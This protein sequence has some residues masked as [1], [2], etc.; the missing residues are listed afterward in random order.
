MI[1]RP[2]APS[3]PTPVSIG[4]STVAATHYQGQAPLLA[5]LP[6]TTGSML[7]SPSLKNGRI[8]HSLAIRPRADYGF[9]PAGEER[10]P[11]DSK[12]LLRHPALIRRA[13]RESS[14]SESEDQF[15]DVADDFDDTI[16]HVSE[17]PFSTDIRQ[18]SEGPQCRA[19]GSIGRRSQETTWD[20][21]EFQSHA[22]DRSSKYSVG[23]RYEGE[24]TEVYDDNTSEPEYDARSTY[25]HA[26]N[27]SV[28][29][30]IWAGRGAFFSP[31]PAD[32]VVSN[33]YDSARGPKRKASAPAAKVP[34]L[35]TSSVAFQHFRNAAEYS[36]PTN[37]QDANLSSTLRQP[38]P[39]TQQGRSGLLSAYSS[40]NLAV[41]SQISDSRDFEHHMAGIAKLATSKGLQSKPITSASYERT[42]ASD[43]SDSRSTAKS[44]VSK[45]ERS[46]RSPV[47]SYDAGVK[48]KRVL[49][50][51]HT[52]AEPFE[53]AVAGGIVH[54]LGVVHDGDLERRISHL[55]PK[56]RKHEPAPWELEGGDVSESGSLS[57]I[58]LPSSPLPQSAW[59]KLTRGSLDVR[60]RDGL[61]VKKGLGLGVNLRTSSSDL[62]RPSTDFN[63]SREASSQDARPLSGASPSPARGPQ[64]RLQSLGSNSGHILQYAVPPE[65]KGDSSSEGYSRVQNIAITSTTIG[66][67]SD[68]V[69]SAAPSASRSPRSRT[70]SVTTS[71]AN[72]LKGFG[73][74]SERKDKPTEGSQNSNKLA[75]ALKKKGE[76][77]ELSLAKGIS[78]A[79]F[80]KQI[81]QESETPLISSAIRAGANKNFLNPFPDRAGKD[82]SQVSADPSVKVKN[83]VPSST[84]SRSETRVQNETFS[85]CSAGVSDA[86]AAMSPAPYPIVLPS[87]DDARN[88]TT[89]TIDTHSTNSF[90]GVN[91]SQSTD[92]TSV[93]DTAKVLPA[94]D[95]ATRNTQSLSNP[96]IVR[97]TSYVLHQ[98]PSVSISAGMAASASTTSASTPMRGMGLGYRKTG[99]TTG[100]S[101]SPSNTSTSTSGFP[102]SPARQGSVEFCAASPLSPR[103]KVMALVADGAASADLLRSASITPI[104][105]FDTVKSSESLQSQPEASSVDQDSG[106]SPKVAMES[107]W[108]AHR[109]SA[110]PS[111]LSNASLPI[112]GSHEGVSYKLISLEQAQA[113]ERAKQQSSRKNSSSEIN[114]DGCRTAHMAESA[115][116]AMS[117][118]TAEDGPESCE[119]SQ[120]SRVMRGKKSGLL[121]GMFGRE[122][123]PSRGQGEHPLPLSTSQQSGLLPSSQTLKSMK[124]FAATEGD[125]NAGAKDD[126]GDLPG[127]R[128]LGLPAL[129]S[130]R[131]VSSI[132]ASLS[133]ALLEKQPTSCILNSQQAYMVKAAAQAFEG[134]GPSSTMS[135]SLLGTDTSSHLSVA[136]GHSPT[137]IVTPPYKTI[138]S[139]VCPT[140][141]V[142]SSG[143]ESST[144]SIFHSPATSPGQLNF[145]DG[146]HKDPNVSSSQGGRNSGEDESAGLAFASNVARPSQLSKGPPKS[147][148]EPTSTKLRCIHTT[149]N[150][151]G[152]S[153]G[154]VEESDNT[155]GPSRFVKSFPAAPSTSCDKDSVEAQMTAAVK[156]RVTEIEACITDLLSEL[157]HLRMTHIPDASV[158]ASAPPMHL[159]RSDI[160]A[161]AK[162]ERSPSFPHCAASSGMIL[163]EVASSTALSDTPAV[164][165][166]SAC[167]CSCA[168]MKRLQ[169]INETQVLRGI[170]SSV[171]DRGRGV[172]KRSEE[173]ASRF[174]GH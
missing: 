5:T 56:V 76:R 173:A 82:P 158:S 50:S 26:R 151:S 106:S 3:G 99:S 120:G 71:A 132:F 131:P 79:D 85:K 116:N 96:S 111:T 69:Y 126:L 108:K 11:D 166:C 87:L 45:R 172:R 61:D 38:S 20:E 118:V 125:P 73:L 88:S 17:G 100:G 47:L 168:E 52:Q 138:K 75:K 51:Q 43:R 58:P 54:G 103:L 35:P 139:E 97:K 128:N 153:T 90:A 133:P 40:P 104:A 93:S 81:A 49:N 162:Q 135:S 33:A 74:G 147:I 114:S 41:E 29:S 66:R 110:M 89:T 92:Q 115:L 127:P 60:D 156:V 164:P 67:T 8:A 39:G 145:Y 152:G 134:N 86:T 72:M 159:S 144:G 160:K 161:R 129:G 21:S 16:N 6:H 167:G 165:A 119:K 13:Q 25:G 112:P 123:L 154:V 78:S 64:T 122:K 18:L 14:S 109:P 63:G 46:K 121:K 95:T 101:L 55:G 27:S 15:K 44:V 102:C 130:I 1:V 157:T 23:T 171:M 155:S 12:T 174:G 142:I 136:R 80:Q 10:L 140:E 24:G 94:K 149:A 105:G 146:T 48:E 107:A 4:T 163:D 19:S 9:P 53:M 150:V 141:E 137:A 84:T 169:A 65:D 148:S 32:F 98:Q 117:S 59:A 62:R 170:G 124:N 77:N 57:S 31:S 7:L 42:N 36:P 37:A 68:S 28:S 30:S 91:A 70:K 83:I 2:R 34:P 22:L 143:V 113:Q